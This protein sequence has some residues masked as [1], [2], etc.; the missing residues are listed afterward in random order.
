MLLATVPLAFYNKDDKSMSMHMQGP[1]PSA[2]HNESSWSSGDQG[3]VFRMWENTECE[4]AETGSEM[5]VQADIDN[6]LSST[7]NELSLYL[8]SGP[9]PV[10][11][12][13]SCDAGT[14]FLTT[15]IHKLSDC[16]D[17]VEVSCFGAHFLDTVESSNAKEL[18]F[19]CKET[20]G[21][22][23]RDIGKCIPQLDSISVKATGN[24]TCPDAPEWYTKRTSKPSQGHD[25][26]HNGTGKTAG[27]PISC[28]TSTLTR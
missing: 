23:N 19:G 15:N 27:E 9:I 16:T 18:P 17:E 13:F 8:G 5:L 2:P 1:P 11:E 26:G 3:V 20:I 6:M 21:G 7:C 12:S 14:S 28:A 22:P 4:G 10:Y 25:S 24:F